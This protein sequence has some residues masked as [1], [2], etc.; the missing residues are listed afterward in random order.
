MK[1][2]K[3]FLGLLFVVGLIL[4]LSACDDDNTVDEDFDPEKSK[5]LVD[6]ANQELE[7][8]LFDLIESEL[9][10]V[11]QPSDIDLSSPNSLYKQALQFDPNND[12]ANFGAALTE[13]LN[14]TQN[15][16]FINAFETWG[17]FLDTAKIFSPSNTL[18][19]FSV[20][21]TGF[22]TSLS[23][24]QM[25]IEAP[26]AM[27]MGMFKLT[28]SSNVPQIGDIQNIL[29]TVALP[30]VNY[31]I[32]RLERITNTSY[33][34]MVTGKMQGDVNEDDIEIDFTEIYALKSV[35]NILKSWLHLSV[36]YNFNIAT[37]DSTGMVNALKQDSGFLAL[38]SDGAS[39]MSSAKTALLAAATNLENAIAFVE[40]ETDNQDDDVIKVGS[41]VPQEVK[42]G[43]TE[44]KEALNGTVKTIK[45]DFNGDNSLENLDVNFASYFDT[46]IPNFKAMV[47]A[48]TVLA[49]IEY[50]ER[51]YW[52]SMSVSATVTGDSSVKYYN[53]Y[54]QISN[55]KTTS[56][57]WGET[58]PEFDSQFDA[59]KDSLINNSIFYDYLYMSLYWSGY[60]KGSTNIFATLSYE[61]NIQT[62]YYVPVITWVATSFDNWILPDPTFNGLFPG[63]T[64]ALFKQTF[65]INASDVGFSES[66]S[67][68]ITATE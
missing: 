39:H 55:G 27:S 19:I 33:I 12:D 45:A 48:Y 8:K 14:L 66:V 41:G 46:P 21:S 58:I 65:N 49:E 29:K 2:Y 57:Q 50:G 35:L 23:N 6:S 67:P 3:Q 22:P 16:S 61:Y 53:R 36:A 62:E 40:A 25:S 68:P 24:Q 5:S 7:A 44:F 47:P 18:D 54:Y 31:S 26:L 38:N 43:I 13:L 4:S 30:A 32:S 20:S 56:N 60:P 59:L 34:F 11:E 51:Y 17:A 10:N 52:N 37:Y 63:M 9:G 1:V 15:Q 28:A 64:D 42:D